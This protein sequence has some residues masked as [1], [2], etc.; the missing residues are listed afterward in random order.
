MLNRALNGY[1]RLLKRGKFKPPSDITNATKK[2]L[3]QANPLP[4]F[5]NECCKTNPSAKCR[6]DQLYPAYEK[7][8]DDAGIKWHQ[9]RLNFTANLEH[10]GFKKRRGTG[11]YATIIGLKIKA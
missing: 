11:G 7:W 2:W 1:V 4:A 9:N 3:N 8:A 6:V 5:I 10:L